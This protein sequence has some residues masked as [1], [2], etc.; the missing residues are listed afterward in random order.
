MASHNS[1]VGNVVSPDKI[2]GTAGKSINGCRLE[3]IGL[4]CE[5]NDV[6]LFNNLSFIVDPGDLVQFDGPNGCG[7]TSLLRMLSGLSLPEEGEVRWCGEDIQAVR[8]E[9]VTE[10]AYV[11]HANGIKGDLSP[12]ENLGLVTRLHRPKT[13]ANTDDALLRIGLAG[14]EDI[15][16][17]KLS[18]GQRRRV[19]LARLLVIDARL[20]ILDEPFTAVDKTGVDLIQDLLA[21]HIQGGGMA[22][23]TSHHPVTVPDATMTN[24]HLGA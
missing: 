4:C 8:S 21:E 3:A 1:Q 7:K 19:A 6:T 9:Y 11:G 10:V 24:I 2:P 22:I 17:R 20:W 23:L 12:Q 18:A 14:Y 13:D 5:R 15:P 16:T